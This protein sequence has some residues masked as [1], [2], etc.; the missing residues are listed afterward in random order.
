ME[1]L[2]KGVT[3]TQEQYK[4][5]VL[6]HNVLGKFLDQANEEDDTPLVINLGEVLQLIGEEIAGKLRGE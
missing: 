6:A 5:L 3:F 1:F 4:A 2:T